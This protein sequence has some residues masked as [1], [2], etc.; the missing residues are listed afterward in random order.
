MVVAPGA[1]QM[2]PQVQ[3]L[4]AGM[5]EL[6]DDAVIALDSH[7]RIG[8]FNQGAE[9]TFGYEAAEVLGQPLDLLLPDRFVASHRAHVGRFAAAPDVARMMQERQNVVGRHK[10]GSELPAEASIAKYTEGGKLFLMVILRDVTA[11]RDAERHL[12][13]TI[14]NLERS[15]A[16]LEHF[17]YVA[18]HDLQEPLRMVASYVQLLQ[19]RYQGQLDDDADEFIAYAVD[20][21]KRMQTLINDLLAYSRVSSRAGELAA[22][23][24][25]VALRRALTN[26]KL[27]IEESGAVVTH[28]PL[29]T[30]M[31]DSTQ[32]EQL[33]QNLIANAIRFRADDPPQVHVGAEHHDGVWQYS[34]R[35][36]GIGIDPQYAERIFVIFK[37][38]HTK[39]N[40][41][42]TGIGLAICKRI[43]ERPE[44]RIWLDSQPGQGATFFFTLPAKGGMTV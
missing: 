22:A 9:R 21:A 30:I 12:K 29:P 8:V 34:V 31:G 23:D 16:E 3:E 10:D 1:V 19:R 27:A 38:L 24:C 43:V 25:E 33:F 7:Q 18:S 26:L 5:L 14:E 17:A 15:N 35:D 36:N 40:Y 13:E 41:G 6:V 4:V 37:R 2:T 20:G 32:L 44:G 11:G 28:D 42:G 39:D